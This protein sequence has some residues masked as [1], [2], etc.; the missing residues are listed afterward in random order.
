MELTIRLRP[1]RRFHC[2]DRAR[3]H[4]DRCELSR[5]LAVFLS[6]LD[7]SAV[8]VSVASVPRQ[9]RTPC[10]QVILELVCWV[11]IEIGS[12]CVK[13]AQH[14][15]AWM[16]QATSAKCRLRVALFESRSDVGP[17]VEDHKCSVLASLFDENQDG[18]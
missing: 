16:G 9:H 7:L 5:V 17:G 8:G 14:D 15:V 12:A 13:P 1:L 10:V 2:N 4:L 11:R 3:L 6:C 18:F